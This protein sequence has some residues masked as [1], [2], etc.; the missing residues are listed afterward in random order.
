MSCYEQC[1]EAAWSEQHNLDGNCPPAAL[2][3]V[4]FKPEKPRRIGQLQGGRVD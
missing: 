3:A 4:G 2:F 1:P